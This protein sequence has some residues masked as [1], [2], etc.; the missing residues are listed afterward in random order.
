MKKAILLSVFFSFSIFHFTL[1][2]N[3]IY[4]LHELVGDTI[5]IQ[6]KI[7]YHLFSE[8]S[9]AAYNYSYI[10]QEG[11]SFKLITHFTNDSI[12]TKT[13]NKKDMEGFSLRIQ[14]FGEFYKRRNSMNSHNNFKSNLDFQNVSNINMR[15]DSL[16]LKEDK[17]IKFSPRIQNYKERQELFD[18]GFVIPT[19]ELELQFKKKKKSKR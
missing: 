6:E 5:D 2:Q 19:L 3:T 14:K 17:E 10:S 13:V 4:Q 8:F 18:Q 15:Y 16:G 1:S 11:I 12:Y 7:A 9:D